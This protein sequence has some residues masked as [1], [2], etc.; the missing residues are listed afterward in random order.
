MIQRLRNLLTRVAAVVV[1]LA[2][3][4]GPP[5]VIALIVGRPWP[6]WDRLRAEIDRG[7]VST[8]TTM[9]LAALVA[10]IVW[11]WAMVII[12]RDVQRVLHERRQPQRPHNHAATARGDQTGGWLQRLVR[13]AVA[14]TLSTAATISTL[15]PSV[16]ALTT[17]HP[18]T[19]STITRSRA[20]PMVVIDDPYLSSRQ[21]DTIVAD[22]R[23]TPL[24][25]AVDLGDESL[26]DEIIT[27]NQSADWSSGVFPAGMEI[28]VPRPANAP[29]RDAT[30]PSLSATPAGEYVIQPGDGLWDVAET[31]LGDGSRYHELEAQLVGQQVAPGVI[32]TAQTR[33]IHPGWIFTYPAQP[34]VTAPTETPVLDG[35]YVVQVGDTLSSIAEANYGDAEQWTRIWDD[36][37]GHD[38]GGGRSFDDPNLIRPGWSLLIPNLDVGAVPPITDDSAHT[39]ESA[40]LPAAT[41]PTATTTESPSPGAD[42]PLT[43]LPTA[44]SAPPATATATPMSPSPPPPKADEPSSAA[45][46]VGRTAPSSA[47]ATAALF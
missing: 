32:Y 39:A 1:L 3:T 17:T 43:P 33:V 12:T 26:R 21:L 37:A 44:V 19:A 24:S 7:Q 25:L 13:I 28:L 9:K 47:Q 46:P 34:A 27:L 8:D 18:A 29:A 10:I 42:E 36:N 22:G 11:A 38:M 45:L 40:T 5:A 6:A 31:F 35:T 4:A 30:P 16:T 23:H 2:M 41:A 15:A 14:G 20:A